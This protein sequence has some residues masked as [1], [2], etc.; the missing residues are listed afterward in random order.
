MS[1]KFWRLLA[2]LALSACFALTAAVV[3]VALAYGSNLRKIREG[4]EVCLAGSRAYDSVA[5]AQ[6]IGRLDLVSFLLTTG[7]LLL[8]VF[9]LMGFWMIRREA[10]DEASR[11]AGDEARRV[12]QLY[13]GL[14]ENGT[15]TYLNVNRAGTNQLP[16]DILDKRAKQQ[17]RDAQAP[18]FDPSTVSVAGATEEGK[19]A[20]NAKPARRS[21]GNQRAPRRDSGSNSSDS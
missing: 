6:M 10:L 14:D 7:G 17:A 19:G 21:R 4:A 15:G 16:Y 20:V 12:A 3:W 11:V 9:A 8:A 13:Y 18:S 5:A 1:F 2:M